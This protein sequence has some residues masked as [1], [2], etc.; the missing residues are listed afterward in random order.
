MDIDE[1]EANTHKCTRYSTCSNTY[2]SYECRC[3]K[4]Y[5]GDGLSECY[6]ENE[7]EAKTHECAPERS[8]VHHLDSK[9]SR[10]CSVIVNLRKVQHASTFMV[11]IGVA[12]LM[13]TEVMGFFVKISMNVKM[14]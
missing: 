12:V 3:D 7:C 10:C 5:T 4:G 13:G 8:T 2:G 6:D 14:A 11:V 9:K 1:C